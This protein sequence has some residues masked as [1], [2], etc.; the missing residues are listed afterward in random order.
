MSEKIFFST[1]Q[2]VHAKNFG[3]LLSRNFQIL[4]IGSDKF[5][6]LA[7][8]R[9]RKRNLPSVKRKAVYQRPLAFRVAVPALF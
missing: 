8:C 3:Q 5:N 6:L 2:R 4:G 9:M 1:I 7:A